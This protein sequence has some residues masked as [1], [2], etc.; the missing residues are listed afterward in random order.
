MPKLI[1]ADLFIVWTKRQCSYIFNYRMPL[2]SQVDPKSVALPNY[3]N[4]NSLFLTGNEALLNKSTLTQPN[5]I[6]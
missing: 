5:K 2:K 3:E 1:P 6:P 4:E